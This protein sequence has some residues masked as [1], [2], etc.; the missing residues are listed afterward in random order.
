[1]VWNHKGVYPIFLCMIKNENL[2]I[3]KF[4]QEDKESKVLL[5]KMKGIS[6]KGKAN[7]I[8]FFVQIVIFYVEM[9]IID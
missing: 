6:L 2:N 9:C 5:T 4:F 8:F 1:M 7:H 3:L